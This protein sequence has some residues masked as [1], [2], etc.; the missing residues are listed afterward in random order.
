[1]GAVKM[2]A[3]GG[4]ERW[5]GGASSSLCRCFLCSRVRAVCRKKASKL[6]PVR[7]LIRPP[8]DTKTCAQS[9]AC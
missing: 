8:S 1:M 3:E 4:Q 5:Q 6:H 2:G 7:K 9:R